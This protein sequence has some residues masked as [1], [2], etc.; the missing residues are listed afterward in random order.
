MSGNSF[1]SMLIIV[2]QELGMHG[3]MHT[4]RRFFGMHAQVFGSC[5]GEMIDVFRS[6][7]LGMILI[8]AFPYQLFLMQK[9]QAFIQGLGAIGISE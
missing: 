5:L 8:G 7:S 6:P 2:V 3:G 9:I 1:L 4:M